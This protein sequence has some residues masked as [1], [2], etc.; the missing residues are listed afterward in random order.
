[1][2][3]IKSSFYLSPIIFL[4]S[5]QVLDTSTGSIKNI[6]ADEN[7]II[8]FYTYI[9]KQ[10][11]NTIPYATARSQLAYAFKT[12]PTN[13]PNHVHSISE[14]FFVLY[15]VIEKYNRHNLKKRKL[16]LKA[17]FPIERKEQ[18]PYTRRVPPLTLISKTSQILLDEYEIMPPSCASGGCIV[19]VVEN[20]EKYFIF[21]I[22]YR[23]DVLI[24][25][26]P[27]KTKA[28]VV[29]HM[30][31]GIRDRSDLSIYDTALRE[32]SEEIEAFTKQQLDSWCVNVKGDYYNSNVAVYPIQIPMTLKDLKT[33]LT[34]T[35]A[36]APKSGIIRESMAVIAIE[37]RNFHTLMFSFKN[38]SNEQKN[39]VPDLP[40]AQNIINLSGKTS[41]L[42]K[43]YFS[44]FVYKLYN[45]QLFSSLQKFIS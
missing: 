4:S 40:L 20:N 14:A 5:E 16:Q 37:S 8:N 1:M 3:E 11:I 21:P 43:L 35:F 33:K 32:C 41:S 25:R 19:S 27:H 18:I 39:Q 15:H 29:I 22:E 13:L 23:N 36:V 26:N 9:R 12:R 31:C 38:R 17:P 34:S 44:D 10:L 28:M 42:S 24:S 7:S 2:E 45:A 30:F 6:Y